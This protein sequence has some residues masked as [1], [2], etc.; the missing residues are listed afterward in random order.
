MTYPLPA[1]RGPVTGEVVVPGSKSETNRALVLA[2]LADGPCRIT[3]ALDSR[4]SALMI[5]ALRALGVA[6]RPDGHALLVEPPARFRAAARVDCGLAGTVMRFVPPIAALA[7]GTSSFV[8]DPHASERPMGPL[9]DGLRQL[10][11]AVDGD[12]LPFSLT[13][14]AD[15]GAEAAI[16][17]S[18]S[19]QFVSGLL[20]VGA[21]LPRG[22]RLT[23]TGSR[24]PSLPHIQ[25][26]VEMLRARGVRI[27]QPDERS[28]L[29]EPGPI[30]AVDATIEPD[31]T[32]AAVFLAA[33]A[34]TGGRVTVPGW[35][36]HSIQPGA[37]FL[38]IIERMGAVVERGAD[39]V[40]VS[41]AGQLSGI[42]VDLTAASELTPVVAALGAL[43]QGS[44]V[45]RGV[46]HIRGHETDRLAALVAELGRAGVPARETEDGLAV[47]GGHRL[48]PALLHTY[49]DHRLVHFAAL[50]AL[51][52]E[53]FAVDDMACVS[54]T[55]P[56]FPG[57]WAGLVG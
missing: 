46:G 40:T 9:L 1:A 3:G 55:M 47:E 2:A 51:R 17:A 33:A 43:A 39:S 13:P 19:S 36:P 32:N 15:L 42:D 54:K 18:G 4:D 49:A 22:L 57:E 52:A 25:M 23:H 26:T 53:G 38:D 21:R 30:A 14:P 56:R 20:L 24:L 41:G 11:V 16:D 27:D 48:T 7:D 35:P 5:D 45:I 31:L 29:V 44:T 34:V 8:G 37:L 6:I 28:W 12:R 10:G 50:L